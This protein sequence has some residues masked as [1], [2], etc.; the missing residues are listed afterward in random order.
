[1]DKRSILGFVL[2][3][4]V[5]LIWLYWNSSTQQKVV[6]N[7]K[8]MPD[9]TLVSDQSKIKQPDTNI[10]KSTGNIIP[11]SLANDSLNIKYGSIFASK[12]IGSTQVPRKKK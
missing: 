1:M 10:A 5:L 8:Q 3:G 12:A 4:V 9:T 11:D 6:Q 2:I 7:N